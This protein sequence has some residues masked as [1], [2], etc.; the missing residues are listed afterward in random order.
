MSD[1]ESPL[2]KS[3]LVHM[4][5]GKSVPRVCVDALND[6]EQTWPGAT[7]HTARPAIVAVVLEALIKETD[8]KWE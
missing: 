7:F 1:K 5:N 2:F 4:A 8:P 3:R 6:F